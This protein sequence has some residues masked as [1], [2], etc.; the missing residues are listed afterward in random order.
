M[1]SVNCEVAWRAAGLSAAMSMSTGGFAVESGKRR[2][3]WAA[4]TGESMSVVRLTVRNL[5]SLRQGAPV[6]VEVGP[7]AAYAAPHA[8]E[9][10]ASAMTSRGISAP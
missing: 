7:A 8:S 3:Y 6:D 4:S 1:A 9:A 10:A 2:K 5:T